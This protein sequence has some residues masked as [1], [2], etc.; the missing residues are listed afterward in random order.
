MKVKY[1]GRNYRRNQLVGLCVFINDRGEF[2]IKNLSDLLE[3]LPLRIR[4]T[5]WF[6]HNGAPLHN[7]RRARHYLEHLQTVGL[8][9]VVLWYV[10]GK[11]AGLKSL[12]LFSRGILKKVLCIK[13]Q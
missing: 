6:Q 2:L 9:E 1:F 12:R 4:K 11:I 8:A 13:L 5:M 10:A 7:N 3:D